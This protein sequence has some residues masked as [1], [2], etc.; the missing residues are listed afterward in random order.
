MNIATLA[1]IK[2]L[3]MLKVQDTRPE[4]DSRVERR[5]SLGCIL[6]PNGNQFVSLGQW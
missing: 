6:K 1:N 2:I 4:G 5:R 3:D